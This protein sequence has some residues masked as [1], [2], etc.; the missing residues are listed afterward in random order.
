MGRHSWFFGREFTEPRSLAF[1]ILPLVENGVDAKGEKGVRS[2]VGCGRNLVQCSVAYP[3]TLDRKS[4][5]RDSDH[6]GELLH[7]Q[8][9]HLYSVQGRT[10]PTNVVILYLCVGL[11][12]LPDPCSD[13]P[14]CLS[15][16]S[17]RFSRP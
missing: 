2:K 7:S 6:E 11:L 12:D 16:L 13:C 9:S 5:T 15:S 17:V 1:R 14:H 3:Q 4:Y 8:Q 10:S